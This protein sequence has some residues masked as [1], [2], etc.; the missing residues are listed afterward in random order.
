MHFLALSRSNVFAVWAPFQTPL[1]EFTVLP[2]TRSWWEWGS[3]SPPQEPLPTLGLRLRISALRSPFMCWCAVKK[4]LTHPSEV[5]KKDM[6]SASNQ[7]CCK[8]FRFTE[9][10][11]NTVTVCMWCVFNLETFRF[12]G[13]EI[14]WRNHER[15]TAKTCRTDKHK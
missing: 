8:G 3:V 9:K 2:Q 6:G 4:L 10:V 14:I 7:N 12:V 1:G 15:E 13:R 5:P 11:E